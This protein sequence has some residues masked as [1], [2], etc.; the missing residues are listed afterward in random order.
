MLGT[1]PIRPRLFAGPLS[2][3]HPNRGKLARRVLPEDVILNLGKGSPVPPVPDLGNGRVHAWGGVLCDPT[4][5]WL[6]RW[7]DPLSGQQKYA[8]LPVETLAAGLVGLGEGFNVMR[9]IPS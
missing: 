1:A 4:V 5:R 6:A 8:F 3:P 9:M 2:Y 7:V